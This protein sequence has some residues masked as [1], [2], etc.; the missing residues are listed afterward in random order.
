MVDWRERRIGLRT[1]GCLPTNQKKG[2]SGTC[3]GKGR[4]NQQF[5]AFSKV[6]RP[7]PDGWA[8]FLRPQVQIELKYVDMFLRLMGND[9]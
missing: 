5:K 4:I 3:K 8:Y 1:Y 9:K 2:F 7:N 6:G